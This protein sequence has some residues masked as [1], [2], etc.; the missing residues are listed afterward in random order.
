MS[1]LSVIWAQ[2]NSTSC[3]KVRFC[4][5]LWESGYWPSSRMLSCSVSRLP[6]LDF[7]H[8]GICLLIFASSNRLPI[9]TYLYCGQ[10][11]ARRW[12]SSGPLSP[13]NGPELCLRLAEPLCLWHYGR[14]H[15]RSLTSGSPTETAITITGQSTAI[16]NWWLQSSTGIRR[17]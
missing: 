15:D 5:D 14:C 7:L 6:I 12:H 13:D 17:Q 16:C 3:N 4:G 8:T 1:S 11:G 2:T 9:T 10:A